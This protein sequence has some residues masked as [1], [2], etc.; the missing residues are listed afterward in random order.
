MA[1]EKNSLEDIVNKAKG[2]IKEIYEYLKS[3]DEIFRKDDATLLDF[4]IGYSVS[5]DGDK[6][7]VYIVPSEVDDD[8]FNEVAFEG[9]YIV[10]KKEVPIDEDLVAKISVFYDMSNDEVSDSI[11]YIV[12]VKIN[13][14][15]LKQVDP[16]FR[17][18]NGYFV[19]DG[20]QEIAEIGEKPLYFHYVKIL[21]DEDTKYNIEKIKEIRDKLLN[22]Q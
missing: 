3:N 21:T 12:P 4:P 6:G 8:Y 1:N 19:A 14:K 7:S 15:L 22:Y 16:Y 18:L 5:I 2:R 11:D 17:E 20:K 10:G 13:M 9:R